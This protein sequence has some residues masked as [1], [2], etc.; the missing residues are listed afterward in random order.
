MLSSS[1]A[2]ST[3]ICACVRVCVLV[4]ESVCVVQTALGLAYL[5][6]SQPQVIHRDLKLDNILLKGIQQHTHT[7][8]HTHTLFICCPRSLR[9]MRRQPLDT[10]R[11]HVCVCVCVCAGASHS[12]MEAKIADFGL[13]A[14]VR[15][16]SAY[17]AR[18]KEVRHALLAI[19]AIFAVHMVCHV[20]LCHVGLWTVLPWI[21]VAVDWLCCHYRC[22]TVPRYPCEPGVPPPQTLMR[23]VPHTHTYTHIHTY[24]HTLHCT[25]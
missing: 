22:S 6:R 15:R 12:V 16:T 24:T 23:C 2:V 13:S 19:G 3:H 11:L 21:C 7:H 8:T 17:E 20:G 10:I 4:C 25:A 18:E 1:A 9:H 5:H 14:L